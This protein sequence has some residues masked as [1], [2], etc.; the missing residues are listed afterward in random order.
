ML[1][2]LGAAAPEGVVKLESGSHEIF[3]YLK[4]SIIYPLKKTSM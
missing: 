3:K 1:L 4:K 2:K